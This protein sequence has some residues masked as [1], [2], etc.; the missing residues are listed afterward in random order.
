MKRSHGRFICDCWTARVQ[1]DRRQSSPTVPRGEVRGTV[2][3]GG[4]EG[5]SRLTGVTAAVLLVL[6]A[7]EGLTLL[8]LQTFLSWHI[9]I[10]MLLVP[11]VGLKL[12][13]TGYRFV[14][15]YAG[16]RDYVRMGAPPTLLRLLGPIVIIS[17]VALF[18]TGVSL[19]AVGPQGGVVLGLHKASFAIWFAAMS[20]HVLAHFLR[21]PGLVAPDM[22]GGEGVAGA[23]L[24]LATVSGA[25]VAGAIV[26]VATLPLIA[27]WTDWIG[28]N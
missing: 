25:I 23:R 11:I 4:T 2:A 1:V 10:G 27:P 6:L 22:R 7:V 14:R 15:Y 24:R 19:A 9:F 26:A 16:H 5:N 28:R 8:S 21:I 3:T 12:A 13:T 17:T 20:L 18:A